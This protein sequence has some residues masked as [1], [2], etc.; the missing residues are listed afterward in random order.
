MCETHR[1]QRR[2]TQERRDPRA[3]SRTID[4]TLINLT[5]RRDLVRADVEDAA[6]RIGH[7]LDAR[8]G[9]VFGMMN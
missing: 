4:H 7:R 6:S 1:G 3:G 8:V 5:E 2:K 9:E